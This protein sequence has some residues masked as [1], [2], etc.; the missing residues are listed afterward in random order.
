M[1]AVRRCVYAATHIIFYSVFHG[2]PLCAALCSLFVLLPASPHRPCLTAAGLQGCRAAD[3]Y[4]RIIVTEAIFLLTKGLQQLHVSESAD[5]ASSIIIQP[6]RAHH[7]AAH[8]KK[9]SCDNFYECSLSHNG[10]MSKWVGTLTMKSDII[11]RICSWSFSE[12]S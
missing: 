9:L 6:L 8:Y 11:V 12:R 4:C 7:C 3:G 10:F 2:R 1:S 5:K